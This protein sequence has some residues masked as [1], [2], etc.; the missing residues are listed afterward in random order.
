MSLFPRL[1]AEEAAE[2]GG[3]VRVLA[4]EVATGS[5]PGRS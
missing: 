3:R 1:I 2:Y 5:P 4:P